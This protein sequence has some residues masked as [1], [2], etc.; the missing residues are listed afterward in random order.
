MAT[1]A[2]GTFRKTPLEVQPRIC[3][4]ELSKG[5]KQLTLSLNDDF[6]KNMGRH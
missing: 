5:Q 4:D 3:K 1:I 2:L 6:R